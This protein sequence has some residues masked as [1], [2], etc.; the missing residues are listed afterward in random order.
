MKKIIYKEKIRD[1]LVISKPTNN[2]FMFDLSEYSDGEKEYYTDQ[3]NELHKKYL[4]D[5]KKLGL[6][7]N[8]R[9]FKEDKIEWLEDETT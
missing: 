1:V 6:S 5:I 2:Y 4:N 9:Y 7:S 3:Y 8:Y